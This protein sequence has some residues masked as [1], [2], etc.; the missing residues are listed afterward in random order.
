M[1][2]V[3]VACLAV[4][5]AVA[6]AAP[7][8]GRLRDP[9]FIAIVRDNRQDRGDGNY[10]FEYEGDNGIYVDGS[11]KQGVSGGSN[12]AGYYRFPLPEG[13]VAEVRYTAD[14]NGFRVQ[15]PLV[16]TPHPLPDHAIEQIRNAEE[17]RRRGIIWD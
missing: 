9:R 17:Q 7:Q 13:G 15:S 2:A 3:V 1:V 4:V 12:M 8:F 14:E 6:V 10:K 5:A 11:G 16:P